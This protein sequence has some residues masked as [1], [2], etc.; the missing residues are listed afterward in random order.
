MKYKKLKLSTILLLG[1]VLANLQAQEAKPAT[2]GEVS[3]SGGS[4]SYTVGQVVYITN[5]GTNGSVSQGVQHPYEIFIV[6]G[7]D[8]AN[9]ISLNCLAYPNPTTDFVILKVENLNLSTLDFQL[10]DMNGNLLEN[11]KVESNETTISMETLVPATY[12][13]IVNDNSKEVIKFK[14]IKY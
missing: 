9:D 1:L 2:G 7:I 5:T 14:I 3:G 4:L 12:F 10:F 13:L 8:E 6:T 11:K